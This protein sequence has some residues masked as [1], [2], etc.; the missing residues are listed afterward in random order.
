MERD[1]DALTI[2]FAVDE[3]VTVVYPGEEAVNK[4]L[5][6]PGET[7]DEMVPETI[8]VA[9]SRT[10]PDGKAEEPEANAYVT[11]CESTAP[12][13]NVRART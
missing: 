7:V 12:S 6:V 8:P 2:K 4:R 10:S 13:L 1:G 3:V 5:K 9:V 11:V